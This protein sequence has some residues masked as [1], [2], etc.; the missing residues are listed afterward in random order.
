VVAYLCWWG[1][2]ESYGIMVTEGGFSVYAI[3]PV[4]RGFVDGDVEEV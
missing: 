4:V 3:F 1:W 2:F